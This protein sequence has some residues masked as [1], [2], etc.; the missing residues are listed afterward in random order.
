M[1]PYPPRHAYCVQCWHCRRH[2]FVFHDG[3][4]GVVLFDELGRGWPRHECAG[5]ELLEAEAVQHYRNSPARRIDR[6][7]AQKKPDMGQECFEAH[8]VIQAG[9]PLR[10][11]SIGADEFAEII[12]CTP[13]DKDIHFFV[14]KKLLHKICEMT[15][16]EIHCKV[17]ARGD[18]RVVFLDWIVPFFSESAALRSLAPSAEMVKECWRVGQCVSEPRG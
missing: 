8:V 17:I 18:G 7:R 11:I 10:E 12:G 16:V 6:V 15:L 1:Q 5:R 9:R 3:N 13:D 14:P 4:G 2:I